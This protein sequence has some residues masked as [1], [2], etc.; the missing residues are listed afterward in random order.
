MSTPTSSADDTAKIKAA[1]VELPHVVSVRFPFHRVLDAQLKH[2]VS[3]DRR[4][5]TQLSHSQ[6]MSFHR[7]WASRSAIHKQHR[8]FLW[9]V[10]S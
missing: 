8:S 4:R 3:R 7:M 2:T 9:N 1:E 6:P 5:S 10:A